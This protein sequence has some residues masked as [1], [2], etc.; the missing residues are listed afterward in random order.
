[1]L[2]L[3]PF[4]SAILQNQVVRCI[5]CLVAGV[6]IG[7][8]FYPTK[9][10]KESLEK[11]HQEEISQLKQTFSQQQQMTAEIYSKT[12]SE[13]KSKQEETQH[14]VDTLTTQITTMKSQQK[15]SYYKLVKPDGTV[16]IRKAT[17]SDTEESN[18]IVTQIHEE[19]QQKITSI[20][21]KWEDIHT[22]KV[23]ELQSTFAS[24]EESYKKEIDTLK[25]TKEV[26]VNKK[27]FGVELGETIEK[28]TY[29]HATGDIFGPVFMGIHGEYGSDHKDIGA[30]IGIRF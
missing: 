6:A 20:E 8:V 2:P 4:V 26:E 7:A 28:N 18:Q 25:Q 21:K 9:S 22:K 29:L 1:M 27:S 17:E 14:K 16:E 5:L 10:I 24:K 23:Q 13:Y 19:F 3:P 12:L 30:G 11:T 15:T